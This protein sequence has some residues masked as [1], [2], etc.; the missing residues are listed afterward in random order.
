MVRWI[1]VFVC[2]GLL[3]SGQVAITPLADLPGETRDPS[4]AHDGKTLAFEWCTPDYK[5]AIYTRP[6][7]GG[8]PKLFLSPL[9]EFEGSPNDVRW[10]PDGQR[11]AFIRFYSHWDSHLVIREAAGGPERD[12]GNVC[13]EAPIWTPDNKYVIASKQPEPDVCKPMLYSASAGKELHGI[14]VKGDSLALS[15]DGRKL[16]FIQGQTIQVAQLSQDLQVIGVP[17]TLVRESRPVSDLRWNRAGTHLMFQASG[18]KNLLYR[19]ATSPAS[20]PEQVASFDSTLSIETLLSDG[21]ALATET[22]RVEATWRADLGATPIALETV[23]ESG[24]SGGIECSPDGRSRVFVTVRNGTPQIMI[25]DADGTNERLLVASIPRPKDPGV[26]GGPLIWGWSPDGTWIAFTFFLSRGN[27]D[28]RSLLYIVPTSGGPP[29]RLA[30]EAYA[31]FAPTWSRDSKSLFAAQTW[32]IEDRA[33]DM[34]S[35][36]VRVDIANGAIVKAAP[37]GMWPKVSPDGKFVYFFTEPYPKLSRVRLENGAE[38]RLREEDDLA[39]GTMVVS[40]HGLYL[41]QDKHQRDLHQYL[42]RFDPETRELTRLLEI[43]FRVESAHLSPDDR[44]LYMRQRDTS[45][46]RIVLLRGLN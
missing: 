8:D 36:L 40:R 1:A 28:V 34:D 30:T 37:N 41:F 39:I 7:S 27:T 17:R 15:P 2:S 32:D 33:H 12:L 9:D 6:L 25:A 24:C 21:A 4:L 46:A 3:A 43:P 5:C 22:T 38:E 14:L 18:D 44:Y 16:A 10:S 23:K 45:R 19:V 29:R 35:P 26:Q 13:M 11:I 42:V 20:K 31:I